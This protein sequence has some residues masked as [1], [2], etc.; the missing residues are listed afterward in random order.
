MQPQN[1]DVINIQLLLDG[2]LDAALGD[3]SSTLNAV[4]NLNAENRVLFDLKQPIAVLEVFYLCHNDPRGAELCD[5][6]S[7]TADDELGH[8]RQRCRLQC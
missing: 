3:D 6:I 7:S 4:H 1:N 8:H 5:K 2:K